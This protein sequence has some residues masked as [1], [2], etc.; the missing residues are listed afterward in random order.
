MLMNTAE[1]MLITHG[2]HFLYHIHEFPK[3]R[4]CLA[5][6]LSIWSVQI[7]PGDSFLKD[8]KLRSSVFCI[9]GMFQDKFFAATLLDSSQ[10]VP[11]TYI[12]V[13]NFCSVSISLL[14][15]LNFVFSSIRKKLMVLQ[16]L[17]DLFKSIWTRL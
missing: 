7:N 14:I 16:N 15:H 2:A 4:F 6:H 1:V 11:F 12:L 8:L 5:V 13:T 3:P 10:S 17:H 9:L